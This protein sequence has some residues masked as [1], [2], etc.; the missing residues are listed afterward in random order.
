[1]CIIEQT[2]IYL[3]RVV[4]VKVVSQILGWAALLVGIIA[5]IIQSVPLAYGAIVIGFISLFIKD[6][7]GMGIT[8]ISF[9][10][11]ALLM[12]NIFS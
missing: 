3:E 4:F 8:G 2:D 11:V 12:A 1:M 6:I 9:G 7:R 10:I 5:L